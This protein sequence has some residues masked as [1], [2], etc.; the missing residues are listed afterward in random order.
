MSLFR[1]YLFNGHCSNIDVLFMKKKNPTT[2]RRRRLNLLILITRWSGSVKDKMA[3]PSHVSKISGETALGSIIWPESAAL[4]LLMMLRMMMK[5]GDVCLWRFFFNL[6]SLAHE[7]GQLDL[8]KLIRNKNLTLFSLFCCFFFRAGAKQ[9]PFWKFDGDFAKKEG[10]VEGRKEEEIICADAKL[11]T[12]SNQTS[13]VEAERS[14]IQRRNVFPF[15]LRLQ[16]FHLLLVL[17]ELLRRTN[18]WS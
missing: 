3:K 6:L 2:L 7:S 12:G 4:L 8:L 17:L 5:V 1:I 13:G 16:H 14:W 15:V 9:E 11:K 10:W 18:I